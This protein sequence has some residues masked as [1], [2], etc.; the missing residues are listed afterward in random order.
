MDKINGETSDGYHT[1]NELYEHR[2]ILTKA[3]FN[4]DKPNCLKSKKHHDGTMFDDYFIVGISTRQG[5]ATYHYHISKW[6]DFQCEEVESFPEWDGHSASDA[7]ERINNHF[8][9]KNSGYKI[10]DLTHN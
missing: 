8:E 5:L 6:D 1:F 2:F 4:S 9:F 10:F 7:I 3:L